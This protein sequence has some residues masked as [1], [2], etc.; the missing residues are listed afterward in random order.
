MPRA[1]PVIAHVDSESRRGPAALR[2]AM[3]DL[4]WQETIS[5]SFVDE[6][7]ERDF[8]GNANPVR[9]INP[10]AQTASVMRSTLIGSLVEVL[11]VNLARKTPRGRVFELGKVFI[12]DDA[13]P[14]GALEVAGVRQPLKLGGVVFGAAAP[15]Q[16][17][18]PE[19]RGVDFFD[20][21]GDLESLFAARAVRFVAA[22]HP[23]LHPGR[24]AAIECDG[25]RIGFVGELHP[26]WRQAYELSASVVVFSS[27]TRRR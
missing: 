24:C 19:Q 10:I 3:A 2:H 12:R 17:S 11:R 25:Q 26:R 27:S 8:A 20:V 16:W 18:A 21:K 13:A 14:D 15:L 6:R 7:S 5:F 22:T 1:G 4:G 23:A 9:V